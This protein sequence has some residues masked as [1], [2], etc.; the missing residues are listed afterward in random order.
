MAGRQP[1][2]GQHDR[3]GQQAEEQEQPGGE[4]T[5]LRVLDEVVTLTN[6]VA[7]DLSG[8]I[9][10]GARIL[11]VQAN[12]DTLVVGDGSGDDLLAKVGI[13]IAS[14]PDKYGKTSDLTQNQKVDTIPGTYEVFSA[15][16][17]VQVYACKADGSA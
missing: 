16:E 14:D 13:G 11:S 8:D 6:A 12:L 1:R 15:P 9:P 5:E 10:A 2:E 7:T 17:D 3:Q 4:G